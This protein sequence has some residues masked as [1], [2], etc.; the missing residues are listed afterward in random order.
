MQKTLTSDNQTAFAAQALEEWAGVNGVEITDAQ[1]AALAEYQARVLDVNR[2][3][4]LTRITDS[5]EFAVKHIID[6]MTL[7]PL[8]P[9]GVSLCDI[10]TG[11]GFPGMVLRIM[12]GDLQITLLDSLRKRVNFLRDAAEM[13]GV[14]AECIHSRAEDHVRTHAAYYDICTARAVAAMDKLVA[15]AL[16]LIKPG[17]IFLA[18][19]NPDI[20][21]EIEN[22]KPAIK[23][24][25]GRVEQI[26]IVQIADGLEHSIVV[27]RKFNPV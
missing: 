22:A 25:G 10:G 23:K 13:L 1:F 14:Q 6:A 26:K 21:E 15:Y 27:I 12:R 5:A 2:H 11:A 4:N 3:M 16:P 7:L 24:Y 20:S 9:Q 8:I 19:K 17:G 18:M